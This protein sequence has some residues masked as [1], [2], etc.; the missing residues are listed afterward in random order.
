VSWTTQWRKRLRACVAANGGHFSTSVVI[1]IQLLVLT[2]GFIIHLY[3]PNKV[4]TSKQQTDKI[5][6]QTKK[7]KEQ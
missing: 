4:A 5:R 7:R 6:I 2:L 1:V 3:S